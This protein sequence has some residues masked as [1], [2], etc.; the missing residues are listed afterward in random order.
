MHLKH[1]LETFGLVTKNRF[2]SILEET[3][4]VHTY[5]YMHKTTLK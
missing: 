2:I 5:K 4:L 1:T 3:E